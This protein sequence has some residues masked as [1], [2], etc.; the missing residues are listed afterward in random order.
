[1]PFLEARPV[2]Y[3]EE[4]ATIADN[5]P[6]K[7]KNNKFARLFEPIGDMFMPPKYDELDVTKFFSPFYMLFFGFCLGDIGYGIVI[8]LIATIGKFILPPKMKS[9]LSLGQLLGV[10]AIVMPVFSGT[11]FGMK[12]GELFPSTAHLFFDDLQMFYL[13]VAFGGL[14]IIFAK[15]VQAFDQMKR[16]GFQHGLSSLG[17]ALLLIAAALVVARSALQLPIPAVVVDIVLYAGAA[18]VLFFSSLSKNLFTRVGKGITAA[19]DITGIFGDL[20]SYI[21][22]FGLATAGGILGFVVNTIGNMIWGAPYVG[23]LIGGLVFLIG[24][25]AVMALSALSA[26]VHPMRLTFVEFYKNVGFTGGG[27]AYKPLRKTKYE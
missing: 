16:N 2:V 17:W 13:A 19:Y 8:F 18:L 14:Q 21:R 6:I 1:M 3:V 27:R 10:A 22:L 12:I 4:N 11:L 26:A 20:L 15:L 23:W 5:P 24:H 25:I 9:L 7:L